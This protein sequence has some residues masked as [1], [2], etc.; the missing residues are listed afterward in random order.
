MHAKRSHNHEATHAD[1]LTNNHFLK[2]PNDAVQSDRPHWH[3]EAAV[4]ARCHSPAAKV[5]AGLA[6]ATVSQIA[7]FPRVRVLIWCLLFSPFFLRPRVDG[8]GDHPRDMS[9]LVGVRVLDEPALEVLVSRG[10]DLA[11]APTAVFRV[12]RRF[13]GRDA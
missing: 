2:M 5:I 4:R 10:A 11:L 9:R 1:K 13:D 8:F 6:A 7:G 12:L 3:S